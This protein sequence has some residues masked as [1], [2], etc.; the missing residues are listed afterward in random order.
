MKTVHNLPRSKNIRGYLSTPHTSWSGA[1]RSGGGML[2]TN[3]LHS[4]NQMQAFLED[5]NAINIY[6]TARRRTSSFC[7]KVCPDFF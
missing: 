3:Q 1:Q 5:P 7:L 4:T 2:Y 6:S